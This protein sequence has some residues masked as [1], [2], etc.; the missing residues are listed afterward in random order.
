VLSPIVIVIIIPKSQMISVLQT[1]A[2]DLEIGFIFL[3][4]VTAIGTD[5]AIDRIKQRIN[6]Q[7]NIF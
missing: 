1:S 7:D 4:I 5:I 2:N 3:E 6:I